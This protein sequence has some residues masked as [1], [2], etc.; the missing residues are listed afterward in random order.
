MESRAIPPLAGSRASTTYKSRLKKGTTIIR[1]GARTPI[2][3]KNCWKGHWD[4]PDGIWDCQL[5]TLLATRPNGFGRS[6]GPQDKGQ[7]VVE[8]IYDAFQGEK[9]PS[10]YRNTMNGTCQDGQ[11]IEQGYDQQVQNGKH[12][13]DAYVYDD[14]PTAK[15]EEDLGVEPQ[16]KGDPRLRL[17]TTSALNQMGLENEDNHRYFLEGLLR[18]RSDDDQRTLASGQVLLSSMFGPEAVAFRNANDGKTPVLAHHTADKAN[19]I[20]SSRRG[21]TICPKQKEVEKRALASKEYTDFYHSDESHTIRQLIDDELEPEGV[22]FGGI[23][24]LMTSMCTDRSIPKVVQDYNRTDAPD[25]DAFA[26]KYGPNR[27]ER[28]LDYVVQNYT[29]M[30]RFNDSELSKMDMG[31]L[32]AEILDYD[33]AFSLVSAHDST[34]YPLMTSLGEKVWNA[35]DFPAYAS[36]MILEFHEVMDKTKGGPPKEFPSGNAF[37][38]VY[39]GNVLTGLMDGCPEHSHLCDLS[40]FTNR[41][42]EF[43]TRQHHGCGVEEGSSDSDDAALSPSTTDNSGDLRFLAVSMAASF[44]LGSLLT[45]L[46][47]RCCRWQPRRRQRAESRLVSTGNAKDSN[48]PDGFMD[49]PDVIIS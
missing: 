23:D 2:H 49:E 15:G 17:F 31:P 3:S 14:G 36:M 12:L 24:C 11:L 42:S 27:F 18:Y 9:V 39:N 19:D 13:R 47:V 7:F 32:W 44:V 6:A 43:A 1:H 4:E 30:S 41:V 48:S 21:T 28:L 16:V 45:C 38:L 33:E 35:T 29:F 20:V 10:P 25:D 46:V 8:K 26:K 22:L 37:R 34:I 5:T 40:V